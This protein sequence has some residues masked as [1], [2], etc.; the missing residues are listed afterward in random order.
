[1]GSLLAWGNYSTGR[2]KE[3]VRVAREFNTIVVLPLDLRTKAPTQCIIELK[4]STVGFKF[5]FKFKCRWGRFST[6]C[7]KMTVEI[8]I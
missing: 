6:E 5:K 2:V 8:H 1:V 3:V 4:T 7:Y